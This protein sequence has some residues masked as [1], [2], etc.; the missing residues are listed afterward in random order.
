MDSSNPNFVKTLGRLPLFTDLSEAELALIAE[1]VSR[2]YF[3]EGSVIFE[4]G[5][6][7]ENILAR[8]RRSL[9]FIRL[10]PAIE[11]EG[12]CLEIAA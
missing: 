1:S 5:D 12:S 10:A 8:C 3:D 7:S 4:E 9:E 6:V 11:P 2:L